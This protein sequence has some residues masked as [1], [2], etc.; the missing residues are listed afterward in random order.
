MGLNIIKYNHWSFNLALIALPY[1]CIHIRSGRRARHGS[2][3]YLPM[4]VFILLL[5]LKDVGHKLGQLVWLR[6]VAAATL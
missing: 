6:F 5:H 3:L 4:S 2:N 1:Q